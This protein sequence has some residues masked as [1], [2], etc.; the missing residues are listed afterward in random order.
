MEA[1]K[2]GTNEKEESERE[3]GSEQHG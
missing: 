1:R 3:G 2:V